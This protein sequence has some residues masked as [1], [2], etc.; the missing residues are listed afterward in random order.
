MKVLNHPVNFR[1]QPGPLVLATGFFDGVHLGHRQVLGSAIK[2]ARDI[3]GEAWVLT[4]EQQPLAVLAPSKCPPLLS[5]PDERL[6][7]ISEVGM[8]GVLMLPFTRRI[9]VQRPESFVRWLCGRRRSGHSITNL[10]EVRCG[11]NWR[12]G[13]QASGTPE[14]LAEL[15]RDYGFDVVV[16][17]YADYKGVEIS[18][19]RIRIAVNEGRLDDA[20]AMLGRSFSVQGRVV[21]GRGVGRT[22]GIATAN[23][24]LETDVLPPVGVYAATIKLDETSYAGVVNLGYCP[25]FVPQRAE[26]PLLEAHLI[27]YSGDIYNR[28]IEVSFTRY[29]RA[30]RRFESAAALMEQMKCDIA[31][32][33]A[34]S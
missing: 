8:D 4:F 29:L 34:E 31:N 9:A 30:E 27:G 12:F 23:L 7:R 21:H 11:A 25:T 24:Q 19:T 17:P 13:R 16:V 1:R 33:L 10:A 18:S 20:A 26:K 3:G 15:G 2:R 28:T 22:L 5:T 32:A 6:Q 14:L